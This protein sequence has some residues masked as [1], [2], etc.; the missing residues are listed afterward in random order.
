MKQLAINI[1]K[2][3]EI[4][5]YSIPD[6]K[7]IEDH[8]EAKQVMK[9]FLVETIENATE[10]SQV[11]VEEAKEILESPLFIEQK[12]IRSLVDKEARVGVK[13]KKQLLLWLQ[14]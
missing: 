2:A 10:K 13:S 14:S 3:E 9:D 7:S 8:N 11:Q 1:F 6:Y 12:G 5:E 4:E